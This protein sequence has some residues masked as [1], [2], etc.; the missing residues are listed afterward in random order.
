MHSLPLMNMSFDDAA[1][2]RYEN[3][4]WILD[5]L[6]DFVNG[7]SSL[8]QR[9]CSCHTTPGQDGILYI[10]LFVFILIKSSK[11]VLVLL[12]EVCV[13][14]VSVSVRIIARCRRH[15]AATWHVRLCYAVV[16]KLELFSRGY[17]SPCCHIATCWWGVRGLHTAIP[18][19][20]PPG[21]CLP[22]VGP[23]LTPWTLLSGICYVCGCVSQWLV[24]KD[25]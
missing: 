9:T 25:A 12:Y 4:K 10:C 11:R 3:I 6:S 16:S 13:Y 17:W 2:I 5:A 23:M 21:S 19:L 8:Q 7:C 24:T 22:Q 15:I 1:E 18:T 14:K 20:G